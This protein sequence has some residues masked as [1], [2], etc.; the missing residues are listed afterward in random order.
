[1]THRFHPIGICLL[2]LACALAGF[3]CKSRGIDFS[4]CVTPTYRLPSGYSQTYRNRLNAFDS[5]PVRKELLNPSLMEL[6]PPVPYTPPPAAAPQAGA[7]W[8][9]SQERMPF[10]PAPAPDSAGKSGNVKQP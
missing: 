7:Q 8:S 10:P 5:K 2:G 1:M 3:G 9:P 4:E 6:P